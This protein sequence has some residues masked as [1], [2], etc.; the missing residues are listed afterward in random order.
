VGVCSSLSLTLSSGCD[1]QYLFLYNINEKILR[2]YIDGKGVT[3][4][5]MDPEDFERLIFNE[6]YYEI[7]S[8]FPDCEV[9]DV[10]P[11]IIRS[12]ATFV[13]KKSRKRD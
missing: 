3:Y 11:N 13:F 7:L 1:K 12:S 2:I 6:I 9:K 5:K 8:V 10:T 4:K